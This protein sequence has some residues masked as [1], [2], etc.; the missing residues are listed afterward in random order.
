MML[1]LFGLMAIAVTWPLA[2][3]PPSLMGLGPTGAQTVPFRLIVP[4]LSRPDRRFL[5]TAAHR[6][7]DRRPPDSS[8]AVP[9]RR[10]IDT[11][12]RGRSRTVPA[13]AAGLRRTGV[14]LS[15]G[16]P[17]RRPTARARVR[18]RDIRARDRPGPG[19]TRPRHGDRRALVSWPFQPPV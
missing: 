8:T 1:E 13:S 11:I 5:E 4:A 10:A 2:V 6:K 19:R 15:C 9:R 12:A 17:W 14:F 18:A 3:I 7:M 16:A